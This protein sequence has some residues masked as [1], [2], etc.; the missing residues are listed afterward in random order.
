M[1][2]RGGGNWKFRPLEYVSLPRRLA[3]TYST[4]PAYSVKTKHQWAKRFGAKRPVSELTKGQAA[5]FLFQRISIAV[6]RFNSVLLKD[7][8]IDDDRLES[9]VHCQTRFY[10]FFFVIFEP[11]EVSLYFNM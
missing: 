4:F 10:M 2:I 3:R 11:P 1:V 7:G 8:F 9:R 6:Q 5:L